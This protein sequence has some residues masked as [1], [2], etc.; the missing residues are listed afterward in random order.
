MQKRL[1]PNTTTTQYSGFTII[2]TLFESQPRHYWTTNKE[3]NT[4]NP[5][6]IPVLCFPETPVLKFALLPYYR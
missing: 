3:T 5:H 2:I 4:L 6:E 1:G